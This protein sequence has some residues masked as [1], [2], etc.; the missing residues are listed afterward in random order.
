PHDGFHKL[1]QIAEQKRGGY[2]VF[3]SNVDGQFQKAGYH[4][5]QVEEC[6]GSIHHFQ[7]VTPCGD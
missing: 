3:T 6:H 4:E 7:C 5:K 2:F 1:L